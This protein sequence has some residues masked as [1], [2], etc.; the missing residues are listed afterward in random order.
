MDAS[1]QLRITIDKA[2]GGYRVHVWMSGERG[3]ALLE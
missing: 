3:V 1:T 2:S